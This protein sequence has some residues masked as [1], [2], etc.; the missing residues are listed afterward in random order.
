VD[1]GGRVFECRQR[2]IPVGDGLHRVL[3]AAVSI[4]MILSDA[5]D[6]GH[7]NAN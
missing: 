6:G 1:S 5:A 4:V 7:G 2:I 3:A